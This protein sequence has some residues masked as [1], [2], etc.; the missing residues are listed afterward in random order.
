MSTREQFTDEQWADASAL[1]TLV[2]MAASLADGKVM[3]SI[4]EMKAGGE[5]LVAG[6]GR[7]PDNVVL[8]HL[9]DGAEAAKAETKEGQEQA[10][11]SNVG[12]V[13]ETL[14]GQIQE[15]ADVARSRL[16]TEEFAQLRE[17]LVGA[18][19][20]VVE[21]LGSGFMGSGEKVTESE[22]AFVARLTQILA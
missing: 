15:G 17:V 11:P 14:V 1:P 21:R 20:A 8:Q 7:Y 9:M 5:V 13:V 10:K 19:T 12:E 16:S 6:A 18:A 3:P 2:I 4:R 22:T